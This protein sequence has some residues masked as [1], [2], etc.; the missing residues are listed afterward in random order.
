MD[1]DIKRCSKCEIIQVIDNFNKDENRK[2]G[3]NS[4]C[5]LCR[6]KYYNENLVK[7]KKYNEQ[8]RERRNIYIKNKREKDVKFRLISN[9]RNRIYKSLKGMTKQSATKDILEIDIET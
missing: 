2:D 5:R 9:T 7:I 4:I 1:E 6:K 3:L 8:N